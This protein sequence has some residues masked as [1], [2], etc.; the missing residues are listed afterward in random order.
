MMNL[1]GGAPLMY[2]GA[3]RAEER[4]AVRAAVMAV[5]AAVM[6][7][8]AARGRARIRS[9]KFEAS[10]HG[11]VAWWLGLGVWSAGGGRSGPV[12]GPGRYRY[13]MQRAYDRIWRRD[14]VGIRNPEMEGDARLS[15]TRTNR[16]VSLL[17][18]LGGLALDHGDGARLAEERTCV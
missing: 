7:R 6:W 11:L 10:Q 13:V 8:G 1:G 4:T 9:S 2:A 16:D 12:R 3:G 17:V 14:S 18:R 15:Q 5:H